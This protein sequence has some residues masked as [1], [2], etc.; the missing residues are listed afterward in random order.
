VVRLWYR[1]FDSI[2]NPA[3]GVA[4][5]DEGGTPIVSANCVEDGYRMVVEEGSQGY[6]DYIFD[7]LPLL[8]G[9]YDLTVAVYDQH[10]AFPYDHQHKVGRFVVR[11]KAVRQRDGLVLLPA[12]WHGSHENLP[13][14]GA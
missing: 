1:A 7:K 14:V 4:I 8:T 13:D 3:F 5:L 9:P 6:V 2:Q 12:R 11:D 10:I